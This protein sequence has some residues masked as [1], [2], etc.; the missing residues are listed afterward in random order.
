MTTGSVLVKIPSN[1]VKIMSNINEIMSSGLYDVSIYPPLENVPL[2][3]AISRRNEWMVNEADLV[4][5]YIKNTYGGAYKS[6]L[7]A[8]KKGKTVINLAEI[9]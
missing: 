1:I 6:F 7:Y 9:K 2:R 4:I 5:A 8:K 3:Y